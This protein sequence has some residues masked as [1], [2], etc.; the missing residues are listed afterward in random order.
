[1]QLCEKEPCGPPASVT[2]TPSAR[3]RAEGHAHEVTL[4]DFDSTH[5]GDRAKIRALRRAGVL[6]AG[7]PHGDPRYD[8]RAPGD[9]R[10]VGRRRGYCAWAGGR[11]P[12]EAEWELAAR[13]PAGTRSPG[14]TATTAALQPRRVRRRPTDGATASSASRRSAR[15][16]TAPPR[17]GLLDMAGNVVGVGGRLVRARRAAV[18]L[19]P[20]RAGEPEG[21]ALRRARAC[22]PRRLLPR[23]AHWLRAAA[24]RASPFAAREVG[25]RCAA[26]VAPSPRVA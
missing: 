16:P 7:L 8:A 14:A 18:R 5:R 4:S 23:G 10:D 1:M 19:S 13:G 9:A 24:R 20:R 12:T 21:P 26:D 15:S 3:I 17:R 6:A 22:G 11:L 25:F 2:A